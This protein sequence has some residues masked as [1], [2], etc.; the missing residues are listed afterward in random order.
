[1]SSASLPGWFVVMTMGA[2][3]AVAESIHQVLQLGERAIGPQALDSFPQASS[4]EFR[5]APQ[6]CG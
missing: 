5:A 1:M 6:F 4:R 2:A 3:F